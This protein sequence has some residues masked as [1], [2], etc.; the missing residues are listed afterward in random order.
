MSNT[1][2]PL[3]A[4][5]ENEIKKAGLWDA[6]QGHVSKLSGL[7]EDALAQEKFRIAGWML[8]EHN[9]T[10]FQNTSKETKIIIAGG[11]A[12]HLKEKMVAEAA[13]Q[14]ITGKDLEDFTATAASL[15]AKA[16][17]RLVVD[18]PGTG[19]TKPMSTIPPA[20]RTV[21]TVR[22]FVKP[23]PLSEEEK[24]KRAA[25]RAADVAKY[26]GGEPQS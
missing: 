5:M 2:N 12:D 7:D 13:E 22:K 26:S 25:S 8:G 17:N 9:K 4:A 6:Y 1:N 19:A 23:Q 3:M 24:A 10:V 21:S 16:A 14:G 11:L 15:A 20:E 18:N